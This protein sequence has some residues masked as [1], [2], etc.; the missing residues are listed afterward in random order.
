M[1]KS[2]SLRE[3]YV[4]RNMLVHVL[5]A[6]RLL[7]KELPRGAEIHHV[8]GNGR[9]NAH[10]NLVICPNHSYHAL[11]HTRTEALD[12]CGNADWRKCCFCKRW[13]APENLAFWKR[14]S[15]SGTVI[16]HRDCANRTLR[17]Y[18]ERNPEWVAKHLARRR[19][20]YAEDAELRE[21]LKAG[22]RRRYSERRNRQAS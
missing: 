20:K 7:G 6:E 11:L 8:D 1:R 2:L 12:A 14:G 9:N 18:K 17:A 22:T 19:K 15:P 21:R 13:D 5:I 3:K 16:A 4:W 10:S